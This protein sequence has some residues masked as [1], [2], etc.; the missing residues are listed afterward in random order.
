M[1]RILLLAALLLS[2]TVTAQSDKCTY[3]PN[4]RNTFFILEPGYQLTL[5]GKED[6]EEVVLVITVLNETKKVGGIETRVVEENESVNGKTVEISR[7]YFAVCKETKDVYYFGEDVDIYKDGK[8]VGHEGSWLAEG[9]IN[10]PGIAMQGKIVI[11]SKYLQE[12][13]PGVAMDKGEIVSDKETMNAPAGNFTNCLK[14]KET[15]ALKPGEKEYK[16]YAPNVG[17]IKD[18]KLT[19]V[20]YGFKS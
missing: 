19:L 16:F 9:G 1:K 17:L 6:N 5:K 4:G 3:Q 10:K 11:G 2:M 15:N 13:A 12:V 14:V 20:K 8:I 7:N 18:D